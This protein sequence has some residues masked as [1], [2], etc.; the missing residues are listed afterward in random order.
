MI[1]L[2]SPYTHPEPAVMQRRFEQVRHVTALLL[3]ANNHVY[4]P[5][6]HCHPIAIAHQLPRDFAFWNQYNLH[7]LSL[8]ERLWV[9]QLP[10]WGASTGV[11]A[12]IAHAQSLSLPISYFTMEHICGEDHSNRG[13]EP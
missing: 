7:M 1:Y 4:S 10:C 9:L 12:E 3:C 2:A 11:A 8:A 13:V 5:I 6:V